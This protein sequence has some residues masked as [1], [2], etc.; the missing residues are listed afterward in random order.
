[1]SI[2]FKIGLLLFCAVVGIASAGIYAQHRITLPG[3]LALEQDETVKDIQ[4]VV[5][6]IENEIDYLDITCLDW[7]A[8]NDTYAFIQSSDPDYIKANLQIDTFE[9]NRLNL[10]YLC[11][12]Q[13][14]VVW[15][16]MRAASS[17]E[18]I[19]ARQFPTNTLPRMHPFL[20]H[21]T[22]EKNPKGLKG[23]FM[24]DHGP[25]LIAARPILKS[26]HEG[27]ARGTL[28]MG[29]CIEHGLNEDL[30]Q[31]VMVDFRIL[32]INKDSMT[33]S[34]KSI[35]GRITAD[36]PYLIIPVDVNQLQAHTV[37]PDITGQ[38]GLLLSLSLPREISARGRDTMRI[39]I[40]LIIIASI[41][42]FLLVFVSM[43]RLVMSPLA[44]LTAHALAARRTCDYSTRVRIHRN[45]E[46]GILAREFDTL[47]AN[48]EQ[49]TKKLK[50]TNQ[51]LERD[52]ALREE[53]TAALLESEQRFRAMLDQAVDAIFVVDMDARFRMVNR[54]ACERL[55]YERY[56][57]LRMKVPDIDPDFEK[58]GDK[59]KIWMNIERKKPPL[60]EAR[61]RRK[62]GGLLP[63]EVSLSPFQYQD[64]TLILA[65]TR[66]ITDR[67]Q[68]EHRL[69]YIHKM[70]AVRT[71]TAGIAHNFNNI[72][73]VIMGSAELVE[74]SIPDDHPA[75]LRLKNIETAVAR[76]RDIVWQLIHF[77]HQDVDE[78]NLVDINKV[79]TDT[80]DSQ[81]TST[82]ANITV[83]AVIEDDCPPV[84]GNSDQIRLMLSNLWENAVEAM[85]D[86]GGTLEVRLEN[87]LLDSP[88]SDKD[89]DMKPGRY[90]RLTVGDNGRG[91][92][93][94]HLD[95]VFDP[96]FT[97]KDFAY[98]AGMGLAIV[99]GIVKGNGGAISVSS[100]SGRGTRVRIFF[101]VINGQ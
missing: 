35:V 14:R 31:R 95:N 13:G 89:P 33:P 61:H 71:L 82:P 58:R 5:A 74:Q 28:I 94:A 93:P 67:K 60:F 90:L 91:I 20:V 42:F 27:P 54:V 100:H 18:M 56:E 84:H 55:G 79:I 87:I 21:S 19:G 17:G 80:V 3:F 36:T 62:D 15:G 29:R 25:M 85:T 2:H 4:R 63:V 50:Q 11:D 24:T 47:L 59:E 92:D 16:E 32:P 22:A 7:A 72:L 77:S 64:E 96:Y 76:A 73:A 70:D 88:I 98:G 49:T 1:M 23:I 57:L 101:P 78:G 75:R 38:A 45:D 97:T 66:D 39:G 40:Y 34:A 46:I 8:R 53:A 68:L 26:N 69:R 99:H 65:I 51:E 37:M 86:R 12:I 41:A 83:Q 43:K 9:N 48:I 81:K 10:I 6:V 44:R 30:I 52:M